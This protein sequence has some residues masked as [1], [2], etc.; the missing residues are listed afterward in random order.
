MC[1]IFLGRF[2]ACLKPCKGGKYL[3]RISDHFDEELSGAG[4]FCTDSLNKRSEWTGV[5]WIGLG[6]LWAGSREKGFDECGRSW[7]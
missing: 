5:G 7:L 2:L 6:G 4:D 1:Y 3:D